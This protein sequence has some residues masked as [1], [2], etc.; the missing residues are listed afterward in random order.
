MLLLKLHHQIGSLNLQ[1]KSKN[2][3]IFEILLIDLQLFQQ[4]GF[5]SRAT[6]I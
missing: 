2:L 4:M 6:K 5:L 3:I 1:Y